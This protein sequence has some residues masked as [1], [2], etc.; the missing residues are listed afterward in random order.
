MAKLKFEKL[1]SSAYPKEKELLINCRILFQKVL[2]LKSMENETASLPPKDG[3][4]YL[5]QI[6]YTIIGTIQT[7]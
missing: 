5:R 3:L 2:I 6:I 1:N 7:L 4:E